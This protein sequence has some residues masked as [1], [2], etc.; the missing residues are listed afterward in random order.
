MNRRLLAMTS[1]LILAPVSSAFAV[2]ST[3]FLT[4]VGTQT[5][6]IVQEQANFG[7]VGT[8]ITPFTQLN[9]SGA[10]NNVV[11]I[12][13]SNAG[14][15][16]GYNAATGSQK[17]STNLA[18]IYQAGNRG[19]VTVNQLGTNN[20]DAI[21][22]DHTIDQKV[23]ADRN[24]VLLYENGIT[25]GFSISQE[26]GANNAVTVVQIG[27]GNAAKTTQNG[28]DLT[29]IIRQLGPSEGNYTLATQLGGQ[30]S[31]DVLQDSAGA[32]HVTSNQDGTGNSAVVV[33]HG[34]GQFVFNTQ[35][36]GGTHSLGNQAW[37]TQTGSGN[38]ARNNQ[39]GFG[40]QATFG[41]YGT[42]NEATLI[43]QNGT[44]NIAMLMQYDDKNTVTLYQNGNANNASSNQS[45]GYQFASLLQNGDGNR[46][47]GMQLGNGSQL[48]N[49]AIVTQGSSTVP[50]SNSVANYSQS[51]SGHS[52]VIK[53]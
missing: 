21:G 12:V 29:I 36:G 30:N 34:S 5:A 48:G 25:N 28:Y 31:L 50:S 13:Q 49:S 7:Q 33:Q 19:S 38:T 45:G 52:L 42:G 32:H 9:G 18:T 15:D 44:T 10:G 53:Q 1:I 4:Q 35:S 46:I 14:P 22:L 26:G 24:V 17:G 43:Y 2:G 37:F 6:D 11:R 8:E 47:V 3:T 51:G 41:Q 27:N 20:G 23:S 39:S 16:S 40:G